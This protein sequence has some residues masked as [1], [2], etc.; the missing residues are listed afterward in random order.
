MTK[1][2]ILLKLT[3]GIFLSPETR[4]LTRDFVV[5]VI[6]QIKKLKT[7]HQFG[8]VI[9]GGNFFRGNQ[10][11]K[12]LGISAAVGHQI[13]MLATMMNGLILKDLLEQ[14]GMSA[15]ILCAIPSPEIGTPISQQT[16]NSGLRQGCT[17][18]FTGGTGN[19]FFTTDTNAVLR[20]L[21]ID[22]A[23]IWKATNVD[24]VYSGNPKTDPDAKLLK[25]ITFKEAL[26]KD[27]HIMDEPS[28]ALADQY[29]KTVR[30]FDIFDHDALIKAAQ[31]PHY[32]SIITKQ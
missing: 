1:K 12:K 17:L 32:G 3:G 15:C 16:I 20:G 14:H 4:E 28:L 27:L 7:T 11:G 24:G 21:Q 29:N 9:G 13:G 8:I 6:E 26:L 22:A 30:V 23:E 10:H 2:R 25:H 5:K 31:D 18:V 19:P